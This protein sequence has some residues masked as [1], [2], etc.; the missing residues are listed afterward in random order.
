M[1]STFQTLLTAVVLAVLV[2]TS[3][4]QRLSESTG[5]NL[6]SNH[7][8]S[9]HGAKLAAGTGG[10]RFCQASHDLQLAVAV[11]FAA[12]GAIDQRAQA[13][14]NFY[15]AFAAGVAALCQRAQVFMLT[16]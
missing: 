13:R 16:C 5:V 9:C 15:A 11:W 2:P 14:C 12:S 6:F 7:C 3:P 1:K 4:A 10:L 8:T